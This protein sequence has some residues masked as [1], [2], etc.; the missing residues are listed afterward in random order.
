MVATSTAIQATNIIR[1]VERPAD[2]PV[3]TLA[4]LKA[5]ICSLE[6]HQCAEGCLFDGYCDTITGEKCMEGHL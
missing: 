5:K 2:T 4:A 1:C 6:I 3:T